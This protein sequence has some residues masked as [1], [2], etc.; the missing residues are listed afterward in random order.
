MTGS[1]ERNSTLINQNYANGVLVTFPLTDFFIQGTLFPV[2]WG[3][4]SRRENNG[5]WREEG[6]GGLLTNVFETIGASILRFTGGCISFVKV[7]Q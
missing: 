2:H 1:N 5:S 6:Q 4:K 7:R 3:G